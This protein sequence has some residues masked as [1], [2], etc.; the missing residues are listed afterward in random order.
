MGGVVGAIRISRGAATVTLTG[1]LAQRMKERVER[2][3]SG[4]V[5]VIQR[6]FQAIADYAEQEWY[7]RRG[8][9]PRTGE[10]GKIDVVTTVNLDAGEATVSIGSRG[11][12]IVQLTGTRGSSRTGNRPYAVFVRSPGV[13]SLA[14]RHV[15]HDQYW[16]SPEA[17]R[18]PYHRPAAWRDDPGM[19]PQKFPAIIVKV[20]GAVGHGYLLET[21]VKKPTRNA[22][23]KLIPQIA[24]AATGS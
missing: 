23:K 3:N 24:K 4:I 20:E 9:Q 13:F 22:V 7:G 6:E 18:G 21:L 10:S 1:D 14:Y 17:D 19:P 2:A 15:T 5:K 12:S 16:A 8:V 11:T